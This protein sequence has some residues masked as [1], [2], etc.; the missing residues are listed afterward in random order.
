MFLA[1]GIAQ[2]KNGQP[3]NIQ[4]VEW[5]K[6]GNTEKINIVRHPVNQR[7]QGARRRKYKRGLLAR[8]FCKGCRG[9]PWLV[10]PLGLH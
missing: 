10:A 6:D 1:S 3:D 4:T 5:Y 8:G 7:A 9:E 2:V